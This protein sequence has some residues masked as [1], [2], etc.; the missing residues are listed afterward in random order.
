MNTVPDLLNILRLQK[1]SNLTFKGS[2]ETVGTATVFGG[3]V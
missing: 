2:S 3:Q 1:L